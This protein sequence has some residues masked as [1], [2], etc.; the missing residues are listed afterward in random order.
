MSAISV[1]DRLGVSAYTETAPV[2]LRSDASEAQLG[3]V[4]RALYR[5]VLGNDYIFGTDAAELQELESLLRNRGLSVR[6][7][8]RLVAKSGAYKKRFLYPNSQTRAI[9]LNFKHLLGRAPT[10]GKDI[11]KHLDIY[12]TEGHD[13]EVDSYIDSPEYM[14]AFG[15]N[16]VPYPRGFVYRPSFQSKDFT[17]L[18]TL[19]Q[20]YATNDRSQGIQPRLMSTLGMGLAPAVRASIKAGSPNPPHLGPAPAGLSGDMFSVEVSRLK[21][22][23]S[24]LAT[25]RRVRR[26]NQRLLVSY[27]Q[28]TMTLQQVLRSG[29]Q[30]IS[31]RRVK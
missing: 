13:G 10:D 5:Q 21:N 3:L 25:S 9:E 8:V 23:P 20:G 2:E 4:L 22:P 27:D 11:A 12:Q 28:L 24:A 15:E 6:E 31:V 1:A 14:E 29:G 26:S 7:F 16:I 17:N 19:Y 30:V 18:F